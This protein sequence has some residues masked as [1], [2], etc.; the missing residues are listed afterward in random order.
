M[1]Q[2]GFGQVAIA[3]TDALRMYGIPSNT[4][5]AWPNSSASNYN[6]QQISPNEV[7]DHDSLERTDSQIYPGN[8]DAMSREEMNRKFLDMRS[9]YS[10]KVA[11]KGGYTKYP[12]RPTFPVTTVPKELPTQQQTYSLL[13]SKN[14]AF[15]GSQRRTYVPQ[16]S[17]IGSGS[18]YKSSSNVDI[19][20][21]E[22]L[23]NMSD[24]DMLDN[25]VYREYG[26]TSSLE[27]QA[28]NHVM[29]HTKHGGRHHKNANDA[30]DGK[31]SNGHL[32]ISQKKVSTEKPP[33]L[34]DKPIVV[35][36]PTKNKDV[37]ERPKS[38]VIDGK[39]SSG[40]L[41]KLFSSKP[42]VGAADAEELLRLKAFVHFD[43]QSVSFSVSGLP[44][45]AAGDR[46]SI[47]ADPASNSSTG[48]SA[49]KS[50]GDAGD[51]ISNSLVQSC[52][53]FRNEIGHSKSGSMS[54][55]MVGSSPLIA[56]K[57]T[58]NDGSSTQGNEA[59]A[60]YHQLCFSVSVLEFPADYAGV[61][62]HPL[63]FV[64]I[65]GFIVEHIDRGATYYRQYFHGRGKNTLLFNFFSQFY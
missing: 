1:T 13:Q 15:A 27:V 56:R 63:G 4:Q 3:E 38:H 33:V 28:P 35:P 48:A 64:S 43:C 45:P 23:N 7:R 41:H 60:V 34:K 10:E 49:I 59:L 20:R 16:G 40:F 9:S 30:V 57:N 11:T 46:N 26:S 53:N 36:R 61:E 50:D 12:R 18:M 42:D 14:P 47:A 24:D 8:R 6:I 2:Q 62:W 39:G 52:A 5:Q 55:W 25:Q 37:K 54:E 22:D 58:D 29:V 19:S 44:G 21:N 32:L 65:N 31:L 51:G 17:T